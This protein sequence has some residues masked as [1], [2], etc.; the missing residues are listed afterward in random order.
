MPY[1]FHMHTHKIN[2]TWLDLTILFG[3]KGTRKIGLNLLFHVCLIY[4]PIAVH[5][6]YEIVGKSHIFTLF[7]KPKG[8]FQALTS[9][10]I[11]NLVC[12]FSQTYIKWY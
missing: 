1:G 5:R 10:K 6:L 4:L 3:L 7:S 2:K 8:S 12:S 11:S 9:Q